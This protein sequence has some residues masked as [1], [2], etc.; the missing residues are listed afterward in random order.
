MTFYDTQM[1]DVVFFGLQ[2]GIAWTLAWHDSDSMGIKF[3]TFDP[4]DVY[5]DIDARKTTQIKDFVF[6][7]VKQKSELK[8]QYETDAFGNPIDW[9]NLGTDKDPTLSDAKKCIL[10]EKDPENQVIV[11]EGYHIVFEPGVKKPYLVR[12]L[13]TSGATLEKTEHREL[14]FIPVSPFVPNGEPEELF[15]R[16]W[17]ADM[18]SLDRK[19]NEVVQKFSK[20]VDTG[21]RYVYVRKG[22][23]L[24]KGTDKLLN[25]LGVEIIEVANSQEVPQQANIMT[26]SQQDIYYL[27][28]LMKQ[29]EDEGGMKSDIMG[30]SSLGAEASGRAI[31]ALQAGSKNNLGQALNELNKYMSRLVRVVLELHKLYSKDK[32]YAAPKE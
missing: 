32:R 20:I 28:F 19:I 30:S 6:T 1:D 9:T 17:Y 29:A 14:S 24:T 13:T 7:Y 4:L 21:G 22:T 31:Q 12:I 2:R 16:S 15:P 27:E 10:K 3:K 11:R 5:V 26:I 18:L 25:S 8:A 23:K